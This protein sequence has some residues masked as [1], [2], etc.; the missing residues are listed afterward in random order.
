MFVHHFRYLIGIFT[1]AY[2]NPVAKEAILTHILHI[3]SIVK[4]NEVEKI[5]EALTDDELDVM[6]KYIYR[7]FEHA[8]TGNCNNLF[9]W[10][11][12]V[13]KKAGVGSIVRVLTDKKR[14]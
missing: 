3:I 5:V 4:T 13:F 10:H 9:V 2:K 8:S 12:K 14:V 7:G 11:D 1:A 6:M